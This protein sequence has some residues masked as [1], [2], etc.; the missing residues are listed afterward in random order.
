MDRLNER[1]KV[2]K[3]YIHKVRFGGYLFL[4]YICGLACSIFSFK[5]VVEKDR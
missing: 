1:R 3:D 2:E 5:F 4:M